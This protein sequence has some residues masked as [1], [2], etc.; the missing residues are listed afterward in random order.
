MGRQKKIRI[1]VHHTQN[2]A[3]YRKKFTSK[4]EVIYTSFS[5]GYILFHKLFSPSR[6]Q[7]VYLLKKHGEM[8]VKR[9]AAILNRSYRSVYDDVEILYN[10]GLLKRKREGKNYLYS[11]AISGISINID[12][13]PDPMSD[14]FELP[15]VAIASVWDNNL[16]KLLRKGFIDKAENI[17]EFSPLWNE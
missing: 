15:L 10:N 5:P 4:S 9:M 11:A 12:F 13:V 2:L 17:E 6:L 8:T 1:S 3:L 14:Y 16:K 7:I